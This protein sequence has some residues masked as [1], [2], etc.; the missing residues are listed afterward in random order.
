M[1]ILYLFISNIAIHFFKI[2]ILFVFC[3]MVVYTVE[4]FVMSTNNLPDQ[5]LILLYFL[6]EYPCHS[7][8]S[9]ED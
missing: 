6:F 8:S 7:I 3:N 5:S 4:K 2:C 9:V 1:S